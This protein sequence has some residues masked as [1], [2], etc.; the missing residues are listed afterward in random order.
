MHI[1]LSPEI[2]Q[3]LQSKVG[4]GFY[5]NAS[6]VVRDAIRRMWEEDEKLTKLR[7]AVQLGDEQ[8][9]R[10]EG[11]AYSSDRL[12]KIT[13]KALGNARNVKKVSTDV[14]P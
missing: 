5:S 4:T 2:E 9:N 8:L 3:Y 14:K 7:A 12:E 10:G 11:V 6:E 13:E 1:N